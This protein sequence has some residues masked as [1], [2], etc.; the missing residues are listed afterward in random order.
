MPGF[1]YLFE[2]FP[3]FTQTFC[4][5][6]VAELRRQG[7]DFS[8]FALR[9]PKDEPPQDWDPAIVA[10]VQN[11]PAEDALVPEIDRLAR[12]TQLPAKVTSELKRWGRESDFLRLYQAAWLGPRLQQLGVRHL[13]AHFA[14]MAARTAYWVERFWNI[15]FSFT[16]HANDVFAPKPFVISLGKIIG[17][18]RA[19]VA[20]SDFEL[21]YLRAKFPAD[22]AKML[23]VY[24]GVELDRFA[25]LNPPN[26]TSTIVSVGRL[27]EKKGFNDLIEACRLLAGRRV[28][29]HCEIIGEG[30]LEGTLRAEI[31]TA[32]LT[33]SVVLTGPLPQSEVIRRLSRSAVFAL[34][35]VAEAGGGMDNLPTVIM[36]A[37]AAGLPVVST[38]LAGVPE[39]VL[40]GVTGLLIPERQPAA[41]SEALA[42]VLLQ[43]ELAHSLG[44]AG[45]ERAA[46]RF[47]VERNVR[48]LR[49]FFEKC[50]G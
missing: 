20:V 44:A 49:A 37:M 28:N 42:R 22:A 24:N 50:A 36:E 33:K 14:G 27:I 34:P 17:A 41:L 47:A 35:C 40:E 9:S 45:R 3:S 6:E 1:A 38:A 21:E 16:A 30:P 23:R 32:G 29:F 25:P 10:R 2:R 31:E 7:L 15:G 18:A 39:M 43:P 19:V 8:I 13:H 26:S 5:R 4:Y 48:E 11:L 46:A 12:K